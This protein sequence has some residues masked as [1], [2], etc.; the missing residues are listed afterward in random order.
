MF[1]HNELEGA[2]AELMTVSSSKAEYE[3]KLFHAEKMQLALTMRSEKAEVRAIAARNELIEASKRFA[4]EIALLKS[5]LAEKDAQLIGGFGRVTGTL[6]GAP[7]ALKPFASHSLA[8]GYGGPGLGKPLGSVRS[9]SRQSEVP[10]GGLGSRR[11]TA[12]PKETVLNDVDGGKEVEGTSNGRER[13]V[14]DSDPDIGKTSTSP[15]GSPTNADVDGAKG[16]SGRVEK[17]GQ[18]VLSDISNADDPAPAKPPDAGRRP[19]EQGVS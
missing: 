5:R 4:H 11:G 9:S 12:S 15:A 13:L 6:P 10:A 7:H 1:R 2:R 14:S 17:D 18:Q 3:K 19:S 8:E 16:T